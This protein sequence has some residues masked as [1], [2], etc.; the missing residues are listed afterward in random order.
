[1]KNSS[2][3]PVPSNPSRLPR[4][5]AVLLG[6][7]AGVL[8]HSHAQ[9]QQTFQVSNNLAGTFDQSTGTRTLD[10]TGTT[11][12]AGFAILDVNLSVTFAK[13]SLDANESPFYDEIIFTLFNP[14]ST[15]NASLIAANSFDIGTAGA[16]FSGTVLFDDAAAQVVNFN[17]NEITAGTFRPVGSL[18]AFNGQAFTGGVF[19]LAIEDTALD[20]ALTFTSATLTI[21][22]IPEPGTTALL[23]LGALLGGVALRRRHHQATQ[24][25]LAVR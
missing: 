7:S 20:N 14:G 1:M 25:R 17:P 5:A 24:A 6:L 4:V 23:A 15:I 22:A 19:N 21:V 12:P 9:A 2:T 8:G 16:S 18:A 10:F 3:L 11:I 13:P